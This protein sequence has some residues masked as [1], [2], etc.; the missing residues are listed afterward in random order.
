[1]A[2][3]WINDFENTTEEK[4]YEI[5]ITRNKN[6]KDAIIIYNSVY[7]YSTRIQTHADTHIHHIH[8]AIKAIPC[9]WFR[10]KNLLPHVLYDSLV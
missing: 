7:M 6:E 8:I 2:M 5:R 10:D 3:S 1:M 4:I 9:T